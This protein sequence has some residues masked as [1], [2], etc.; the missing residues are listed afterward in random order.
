MAPLTWDQVGERKFETGIDR[1]VLYI[2]DAGG[3]YIDG[4]AWS[5]LVTVTEKPTGATPNKKYADNIPYLNLYSAEEFGATIEAITYPDEFA[6]FDGLAIPI[7]GLAIGQQTRRSFGLCY[8]TRVGNDIAGID[9]G[10]KLHLVYGCTASPS[11]KGY[12]TVNDTPDTI[13]FSWDLTTQPVMV[14]GHK[15][16]A[17]LTLNST[18]LNAAALADLEDILYGTAAIDPSL[19]LPGAIIA[20]FTGTVVEVAPAVPAFNQATNTITIPNV[21]G[22][23]YYIAGAPVAAGPVVITEDTLVQ[24]RPDDGFVFPGGVDDDWFFNF[25]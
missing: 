4:V 23:T 12:G 10:Y 20:M 17:I 8:R 19:P 9:Y 14:P 15:P 13:A 18:E 3:A 11:E 24:A 5:G 21:A 2:P 22:V 1:G 25:V 16:S 6:Q 7:P